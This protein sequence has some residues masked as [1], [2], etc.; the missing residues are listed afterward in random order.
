MYKP[1]KE[2]LVVTCLSN[3]FF[4]SST[5]IASQ[6]A[7]LDD[8]SQALLFM[9]TDR[10]TPATVIGTRSHRFLKTGASQ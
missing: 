10:N 8:N 2:Q 7:L 3:S 6:L 5:S 1:Y 9:E 4:R